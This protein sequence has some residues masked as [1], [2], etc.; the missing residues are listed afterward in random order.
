MLVGELVPDPRVAGVLAGASWR[1]Q[2]KEGGSRLGDH[3][4]LP[5]QAQGQVKGRHL[6]NEFQVLHR[7]DIGES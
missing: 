6:L 2:R 3:G 7:E 5:G 4:H 1:P